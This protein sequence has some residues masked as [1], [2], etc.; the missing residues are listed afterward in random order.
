[1]ATETSTSRSR[2]KRSIWLNSVAVGLGVVWV[3]IIVYRGDRLAGWWG[4]VEAGAFLCIAL[5]VLLGAKMWNK[6]ERDG[7]AADRLDV[8]S[9]KDSDD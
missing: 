8:D 3:L 2:D 6:Q 5:L 7:I 1:M 4:V 9:E